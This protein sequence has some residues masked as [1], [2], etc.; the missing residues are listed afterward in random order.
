MKR[1]LTLFHLVLALFF[2]GGLE[3]Q[4]LYE[5]TSPQGK[6]SYLFGTLHL[7]KS[8]HFREN[9]PEVNKAYQNAK[10]VVV[11]TVIDS[12]Q[13]PKLGRLALLEEGD[14]S[15]LLTEAEYQQ[16]E[17]VM[18]QYSPYPM[19]MLKRFKPMQLMLMVTMKQYQELGLSMQNAE[20]M[21]VDQ[22]FGWAARQNGQE[23][24]ALESLK[25]QFNLLF[26]AMSDS[27]QADMLME[28]I[29]NPQESQDLARKMAR[30]Y[31]KGKLKRLGVLYQKEEGEFQNMGFLLEERNKR[32]MEKLPAILAQGDAFVAVGAL[33]L[34]LE[35][36][37][38]RLL[39]KQG[40]EVKPVK[41]P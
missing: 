12:S 27:A 1:I 26:N 33:H 23:V 13:L 22:Y 28:M 10:M 4:L 38:L 37:L 30:L 35:N 19:A 8:G 7:M 32:W 39:E 31:Q 40:Y 41:R 17:K 5:V 18:P 14:L 21:V 6:T 3:G 20:G 16:V 25:E 36:G 11:E 2:T 24:V 29:Q 15:D 9:Y 34:P